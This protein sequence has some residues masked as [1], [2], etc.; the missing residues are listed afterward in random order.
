MDRAGRTQPDGISSNWNGDRSLVPT[1]IKV[2]FYGVRAIS[3]GG[4]DRTGAPRPR[5]CRLPGERPRIRPR[6]LPQPDRGGKF[7]HPTSYARRSVAV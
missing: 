7:L 1:G 5:H 4:R 3:G 6:R 2:Q